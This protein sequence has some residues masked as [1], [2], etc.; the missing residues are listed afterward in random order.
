MKELIYILKPLR[1]K[2]L[3]EVWLKWFLRLESGA[4]CIV[5]AMLLF[6]KLTIISNLALICS[7][8]VL[9]AAF[10]SIVLAFA[11]RISF[12]KA[13]KIGDRLG[14]E[15]R[16]TTAFEILEQ[17][18]KS[19][20]VM[21]QLAVQ[22]AIQSGSNAMLQKKYRL[23][24][25]KKLLKT[26][27]VLIL[28]CFATGFLKSP[29]AQIEE[30]ISKELKE[31][32]EIKKDLDE[33]KDISKQEL[34]KLNQELNV[35]M[36]NIKLSQTKSDA[37]KTVQRTQQELKKLEKN[38][39]A[40]DI[41]KLG[42]ELAQNESTKSLAEALQKGNSSALNKEI[43]NLNEA[44]KNSNQAEKKELSE[45]LKK[46]AEG[47]ENKELQN[48]M[49]QFAQEAANGNSDENSNGSKELSQ[50][51]KQSTSENE[52]IRKGIEKLNDKLTDMSQ[53]LQGE[54]DDSSQSVAK[55]EQN[56]Q[57]GEE[58][59]NGEQQGDGQEA[60]GQEGTGTGSKA[61]GQGQTGEQPGGQGRGS[62]H[63]DSEEIYTRGAQDKS[64][65][66]TKINTQEHEGGQTE[67]SEQKTVGTAGE[68]VP[69][70]SVYHDY[71][72]DALKQIDQSDIPYGMKSLVEEYFSTLEK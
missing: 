47:L 70:D 29:N 16:F 7:I 51:L 3:F 15:D 48:A 32:K 61:N 2:L 42:Q 12:Y 10:L 25:P 14:Y 53:S 5:L 71:K 24:L 26:G 41:K 6:S 64:G 54:S 31:I 72:N 38:S 39:V 1:K 4:L 20:T 9:M 66:D 27:A 23:R 55:A 40:D 8:I 67:Q 56:G 59:G 60:E 37:V 22:D 36:K 17:K 50:T 43:Q 46:A 44:I 65:Y 13:A 68:S 62:G 52:S 18:E 33:E 11:N 21:E 58:E 28:A 45:A 19:K 30:M 69:Y 63:I 49:V 57:E 34:N 35:L